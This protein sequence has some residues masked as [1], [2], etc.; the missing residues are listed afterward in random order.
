MLSYH[1][2]CARSSSSC[3]T[4]HAPRINK[5]NPFVV[6]TLPLSANLETIWE[7]CQSVMGRIGIK[8]IKDFFSIIGMFK[9]AIQ[10]KAKAQE[11]CAQMV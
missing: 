10:K 8:H 6:S 4:P 11:T 1:H 3:S 2:L 5:S 7:P 9:T